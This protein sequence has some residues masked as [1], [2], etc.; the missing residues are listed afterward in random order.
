MAAL[1]ASITLGGLRWRHADFA[2]A[3]KDHSKMRIDACV[4]WQKGQKAGDQAASVATRSSLTRTIVAPSPAAST[5]MPIGTIPVPGSTICLAVLSHAPSR[6]H[7][8]R[9]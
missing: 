8:R 5:T 6:R 1:M 3:F 9:H 2:T 4:S 7:Q